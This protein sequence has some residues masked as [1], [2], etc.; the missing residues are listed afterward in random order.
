MINFY[1]VFLKP[2]KN[3]NENLNN[4]KKFYNHQQKA[5]IESQQ[6]SFMA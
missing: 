1:M 5:I 4:L 2:I 6:Y 3:Y